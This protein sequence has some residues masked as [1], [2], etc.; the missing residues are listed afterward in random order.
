MVTYWS[1]AGARRRDLLG[2]RGRSDERGGLARDLVDDVERL[3]VCKPGLLLDDADLLLAV[4]GLGRGRRAAALVVVR[5]A[6]L[7]AN[8]DAEGGVAREEA[9]RARDR[10]LRV[11]RERDVRD[12]TATLALMLVRLRGDSSRYIE[13]GASFA[14][15]PSADEDGVGSVSIPFE[16]FLPRWRGYDRTGTLDLTALSE[17]SFQLLFQDGPFTLRLKEISLVDTITPPMDPAPAVDPTP[18][19]VRAAIDAAT[20]RAD[21]LVGKGY[22]AQA[23]VVLAATARAVS[24]TLAGVNDTSRAQEALAAATAQAAEIVAMDEPGR[25]GSTSGPRPG[26]G[27]GGR[28]RVADALGPR[29]GLRGG[30]PGR[31]R[32]RLHG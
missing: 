27:G 14:V 13:F 10:D 11:A 15:R 25:A 23:A 4:H 30:S 3:E 24:T 19:A 9:D 18:T 29:H 2:F 5:P 26:Q 21:Y 16:E 22:A 31:D 6:V 1:P 7:E 28:G 8:A 12:E 17:L 32:R 20:S